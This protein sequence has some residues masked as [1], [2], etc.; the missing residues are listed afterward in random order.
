LKEVDEAIGDP[1]AVQEFVI[2]ALNDIL[3]VQV[4]PDAKGRGFKI[5][6]GNMP[7][8]LRALLPESDEP[9]AV[10]F[11]SPTAEGFY[12][13][14]RNHRFVEQLCQLV[15]GNT[16]A[17]EG[18]RAARAAVIRTRQVQTK[19]TLL[20]F[21]CRNVIEESSAR[22]QVVAEEMVLWG[23]RGTP[24]QKEFID[25]AT[26]KCLLLAARAASDLTPQARAGFLDNE[27]QLLAKLKDEF[28]AVA[29]RQSVKLVQ[30]HE[31]FS[32]L[33]DAKKFQVVYPVLPMDLMGVYI[34][35]PES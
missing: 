17:R 9:L 12:Y 19:T 18:K 28:D 13:I 10:S 16:L 34:L 20:L 30:A 33:M 7:A 8:P 5:V 14:G 22:H 31:R 35:L 27:L 26:G 29:E 15:M 11:E 6:L 1:K 23:W 21:R 4:I 3:G 2:T 32:A 24:A 25:H